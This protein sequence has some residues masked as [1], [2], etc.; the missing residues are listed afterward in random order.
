MSSQEGRIGR[1]ALVARVM[2]RLP[3][4]DDDTLELVDRLTAKAVNGAPP[5]QPQGMSRRS[6]VATTLAG[7]VIVAAAGGL[8]VWQLGTRRDAARARDAVMLR[9][10]VA[11]Y[12]EMEAA[13]LDE[14]VELALSLLDPLFAALR[15]G[16][17]NLLSAIESARSALLDFQSRFPS[18][19]SA[20]QWLEEQWAAISQQLSELEGEVG[21]AAGL[22]A[23]LSETLGNFMAGVVEE[24]PPATADQSG[25]SL[26]RMGQIIVATPPL[27]QGLHS[28]LLEPM[29]GWFTPRVDA[30][31]NGWIIYPLLTTV[32]DPAQRLA[33]KLLDAAD[34]W[35]N[36]FA[37]PARQSL[38]QRA[39]ARAEIAQLYQEDGP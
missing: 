24:L 23:P 1:A 20:V 27:V 5:D 9:R 18:L 19:Q 7:A 31:L 3:R 12:E 14:R 36:R 13:G 37:T 16:A 30:G 33:Q 29:S 25:D 17:T 28:R 32:L 10:A 39:T 21:Q 38:A 2:D 34:V 11:L 15:A 26:E 6:F 8:G 22:S 35:E 4:L